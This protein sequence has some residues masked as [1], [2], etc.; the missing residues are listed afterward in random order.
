MCRDN[1]DD[2]ENGNF[3]NIIGINNYDTE[4]L[5]QQRNLLIFIVILVGYNHFNFSL[6]SIIGDPSRSTT[7]QKEPLRIN[8]HERPLERARR[9]SP[10][11]GATE[12]KF[13][14]CPRIG[15]GN[16]NNGF[17]IIV[18]STLVGY[19]HFNFSLASIIGDPSRSTTSQKEPLRINTHERP[20][21][22]A[23]RA[24]PR[25]G[26]TEEKFAACPR[27]GGEI[28]N[29]GNKIGINNYDTERLQQQ[30][31]LLLIIIFLSFIVISTLVGYNHFNFSLASIIGD[32]SRSTTSHIEPLRIKTYQRP[33]ERARRVSF[34]SG[35]TEAK[36]ASCSQ[37]YSLLLPLFLHRRPSSFSSLG[38]LV[39]EN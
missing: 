19:N 29:N 16:K 24:S 31:T 20:L 9:A 38:F 4:R 39:S 7:S 37:K 33:L 36:F 27:I 3:S 35:A 23:R 21:E 28:K 32:P 26:A 1:N 8:T 14:A 22:R 25:S 15:G 5:Q 18:I 10:R 6:A 34:R 12:E 30:R 17:F 13:A 2:Y 11:S